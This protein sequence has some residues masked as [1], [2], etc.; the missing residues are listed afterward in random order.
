[1]AFGQICFIA[2]AGAVVTI[3][4]MTSYVIL[5]T[6]YETEYPFLDEDLRIMEDDKLNLYKWVFQPDIV[7]G[8]LAMI[9]CI[10][11]IGGHFPSFELQAR[12]ATRYM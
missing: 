10:R 7:P 6:G 9:G 5:I 3:V 12:W 1:M 8:T 11:P 2:I 4:Q